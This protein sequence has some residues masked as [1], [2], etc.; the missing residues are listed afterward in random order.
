M[1]S[2]FIASCAEDH[3]AAAHF[4]LRAF[5]VINMEMDGKHII[6]ES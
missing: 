3:I 4:N 1:L 2:D 6:I 5:I